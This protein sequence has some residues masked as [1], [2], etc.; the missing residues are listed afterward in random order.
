MAGRRRVKVP[1]DEIR[2]R[3]PSLSALAAPVNEGDP[4][5]VA[6]KARPD[7][8]HALLADFIK[9]AY[10]TPGRIGQ[11]PMP[12]EEQV[13]FKTLIYGEENDE[14]LTSVLKRLVKTDMGSFAR[15][16]HM[17]R[18]QC[19]RMFSGQYHP[20][21]AE[22]R[23]IASAVNKPVTYFVE[24]R[25]AMVLRALIEMFEQ[26]PGMATSLYRRYLEVRME[27]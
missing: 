18:T 1:L 11:R 12:K 2:S 21:V 22:L 23:L 17:S 5:A 4:W 19:Q 14:P 26:R 6:F 20:T 16:V 8:M 13:D 25:N 15:S 7:A 3:Y 27:G 24:Y 10:A 9:Q